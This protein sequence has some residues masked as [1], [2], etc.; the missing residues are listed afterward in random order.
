MLL[1]FNVSHDGGKTF[2]N[3]LLGHII[4]KIFKKGQSIKSAYFHIERKMSK[5]VLKNIAIICFFSPP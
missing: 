1:Y 2:E 5:P 3:H 4:I